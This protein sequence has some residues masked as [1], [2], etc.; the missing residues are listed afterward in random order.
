ME[1]IPGVTD[2]SDSWANI[3]DESQEDAR[4][5]KQNTHESQTATDED[6]RKVQQDKDESHEDQVEPLNYTWPHLDT[7]QEIEDYVASVR[8]QLVASPPSSPLRQ[9]DSDDEGDED[10]AAAAADDPDEDEDISMKTQPFY[11]HKIEFRKKGCEQYFTFDKL[12]LKKAELEE[13]VATANENGL[14]KIT[15]EWI[16]NTSKKVKNNLSAQK[17]RNKKE[18]EEKELQDLVRDR[19]QVLQQNIEK[20]K[21]L[22]KGIREKEEE[23]TRLTNLTMLKKFKIRSRLQFNK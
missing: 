8:A 3:A 21:R 16:F 4:M 5:V 13:I 15:N 23:I 18:R 10:D 9:D 7:Q 11:K 12:F 2:F 19:S 6:V 20:E 17:S 1:T 22:R 14:D